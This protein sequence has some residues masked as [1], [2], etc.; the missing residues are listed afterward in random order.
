MCNIELPYDPEIALL[1]VYP[2]EMK[3]MSLQKKTCTQMFIAALFIMARNGNNP[4]FC[5]PTNG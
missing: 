5:L 3:I 4:H 1:G 2:G